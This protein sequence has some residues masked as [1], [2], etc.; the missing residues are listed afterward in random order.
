MAPLV[1]VEMLMMLDNMPKLRYDN[2]PLWKANFASV[3]R[4][5]PAARALLFESDAQ[6]GS[7]IIEVTFE[8]ATGN[9][10]TELMDIS[11]LDRQLVS[12]IV[13]HCEHEGG[14]A[15]SSFIYGFPPDEGK[16]CWKSGRALY[17]HLKQQLS[18]NAYARKIIIHNEL[19]TLDTYSSDIFA[20]CQ[21]AR[22]LAT[23]AHL[24]GESIEDDCLIAYLEKATDHGKYARTWDFI[25]AGTPKTFQNAS[26]AL[27]RAY[28]L[29]KGTP[30]GNRNSRGGRA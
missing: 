1:S 21:R 23:E 8:G 20:I 11:R 26:N 2:W 24:L 18:Y 9:A 30:R 12:V 4:S 6:A 14:N 3:V 10:H 5:S 16:P 7:N 15:V 28:Q 13:S 27:I 29:E 17:K 22:A 19:A 25:E